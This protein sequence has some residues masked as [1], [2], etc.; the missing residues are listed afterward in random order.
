MRASQVIDS[1]SLLSAVIDRIREE[2]MKAQRARAEGTASGKVGAEL[3]ESAGLFQGL[4]QLAGKILDNCQDPK[5]GSSGLASDS[6][7]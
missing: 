2:N 1:E 6:G 3:K 4:I 5:G 7:L